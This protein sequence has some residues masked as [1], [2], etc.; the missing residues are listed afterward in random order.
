MA[1]PTAMFDLCERARAG[2]EYLNSNVDRR[3]GCLPYFATM[4]K[5]DP[6]EARERMPSPYGVISLVYQGRLLADH[7]ISATRFKNILQKDLKLRSTS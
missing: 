2:L 7:P 1:D 5:N 3:R 4:F 6:A